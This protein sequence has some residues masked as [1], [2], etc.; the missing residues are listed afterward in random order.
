MSDLSVCC[1]ECFADDWLRSKIQREAQRVGDCA[2]CG[3]VGVPLL[4]TI[5]LRSAFENLMTC[6]A[7]VAYGENMYPDE[8]PIDVGEFPAV[9]VQEDFEVFSDRL[10]DDRQQARLLGEIL[11]RPG[12]RGCSRSFDESGLY[13]RRETLF[14]I[15][16]TDE[17]HRF[18]GRV[19]ADPRTNGEFA[20]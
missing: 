12:D 16:L 18:C 20:K 1:P 10:D 14:D 6:Y 15:S 4:D 17:W 8:S 3:S 11:W 9:L 19:K 7:P 5:A 2:H 13:T